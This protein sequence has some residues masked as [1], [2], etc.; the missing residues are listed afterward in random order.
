MKMANLVQYVVVNGDIVRKLNWPLG[1]V[2]AQCCHATTAIN[3]I[4]SDD[5]QTQEYFANLDSM[6]KVVLEVRK[7]ICLLILLRIY[8]I[9]RLIFRPNRKKN[10]V[11]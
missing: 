11:L 4:T 1:A 5:A 7:F 9:L 6:H 8:A 10:Y 2:I 3:H